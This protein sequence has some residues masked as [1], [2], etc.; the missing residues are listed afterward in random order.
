MMSDFWVGGYFYQNR[1][2][3]NKIGSG[4]KNRTS[5]MDGP[6]VT[7][8]VQEKNCVIFF[9]SGAVVD[10]WPSTIGI[11]ATT[12]TQIAVVGE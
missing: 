11:L 9:G 8:L 10:P 3:Y 7:Q 4:P 6:L 5:F 12:L 2:T 1:T